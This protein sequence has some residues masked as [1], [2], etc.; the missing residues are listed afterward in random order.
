MIWSISRAELRRWIYHL[1]RLAVSNGF[2]VCVDLGRAIGR[3]LPGAECI[4]R[5]SKCTIVR[6]TYNELY[7]RRLPEIPLIQ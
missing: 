5:R 2:Y 3:L 7:M 1:W 4:T 6:L